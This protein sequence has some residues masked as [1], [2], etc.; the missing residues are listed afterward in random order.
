[1]ARRIEDLEIDQDLSFERREY[2]VQRI[3]R[4]AMV[5]IVVAALLGYA[6]TGPLSLTQTESSTGSLGVIYERFGRRGHST[7]ITL[8]VDGSVAENGEI[9]VWVSSDYLDRMQLDGITPQPD[10][11]ASADEGV[12]YTFLVDEPGD[13]LTVN[14]NLTI[15]AMGPETGRIGLRNGDIIE[16]SHFFLP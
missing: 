12:V 13:P 11:A 4:A 3:G 14:F 16:L 15:D 5:L 6:G 8:H 10:Q 1:M 7:D 2:V 9:D